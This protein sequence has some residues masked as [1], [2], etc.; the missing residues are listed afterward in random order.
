MEYSVEEYADI[1]LVYGMANCNS[2]EARR[3]YGERYPNRRLPTHN[4]FINTY[5]RLR[6]A[7]NFNFREPRLN[8]WRPNP[9]I[10]EAIIEMIREDATLSIQQ[11]AN[12]LN[13]S[14]WKVWAVLHAENLHPFHYTPV[15][16]KLF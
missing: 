11:I 7:G 13:V 4:T 16:G 8:R 15:Q 6:E 2:R 10:D 14:T 9:R 3:I 12:R 5:R 1:V